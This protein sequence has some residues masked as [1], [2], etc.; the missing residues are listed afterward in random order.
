MRV[1]STEGE[2]LIYA[3]REMA[4]DVLAVRDEIESERRLP[5][6]L[7]EKMRAARFFELWLP[8]ALGGPALHPLDFLAVIEELS[9]ADG[10]VGWCAMI[11][12]SISVLAGS[13]NEC[14]ARDIFANRA[15]IAGQV[16]PTGKAVVV[17]DGYWV[18]GRWG[19][20]SGIGHSQWVFANCM[21][22]DEAGPRRLPGGGPE[23]RF[24]FVPKSDV[25][26]I[27][28]WQVGGLRGTGSHDYAIEN[29]FVPASNT[30]PAFEATG[31]QPGT[32]YRMPIP[33]LFPWA[34]A[35]VAL[36]LARAAID[37]FVELAAMKTPVLSQTLLRDKP[38]AQSAVGR[39]DA[40]LR[41][42]RAGLIDAIESQ[43]QEVAAGP[44]PSLAGRAGVRSATAFA[45]EACLGAIELVYN[46][47]GGSAIL[48]SGRLDRCF[49]DA[50]VAVQHV[51]LSTN[52][53]EPSGR[54]L[55]G[56]EPGLPRF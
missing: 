15:I 55:L 31:V 3:A 13:L 51:G 25:E 30:M 48:A 29:V 45:G 50:R 26:V 53:Y 35:A 8:E 28:T 23:M 33:S 44:P 9:A 21:V 10:S 19:Y 34:L 56:L 14:A 24:V 42:A 49:R 20:G 1:I 27:D 7:V 40:I 41:A 39:A 6:A 2:G 4:S 22:H 37:T 36:G 46:A 5:E 32:L 12:S 47:A 54:V 43:W 52:N 38:V 16:S 11:G 18:S 17:D